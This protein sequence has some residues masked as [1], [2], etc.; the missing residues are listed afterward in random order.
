MI[1]YTV[2]GI[3]FILFFLCIYR[4]NTVESFNNVKSKPLLGICSNIIMKLIIL[5][6]LKKR[7]KKLFR[8][9]IIVSYS[10]E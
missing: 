9:K 2:E 4:N 5:I 1:N 10:F 7:R 3:D 6:I 8:F